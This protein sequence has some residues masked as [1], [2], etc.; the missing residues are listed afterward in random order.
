VT[1]IIPGEILTKRLNE[2][3]AKSLGAEL[4]EIV[5]QLEQ[6]YAPYFKAV[7]EWWK[8]YEAV[9]RT[10]TKNFPFKNASNVVVPFIK[11]QVDAAVSR[12]FSTFTRTDRIWM[13]RTEN[14]NNEKLANNV[15]RRINWGARGNDFDYKLFLYDYI[16]ELYPIG[17]ACAAINYRSELRPVFFGRGTNNRATLKQRLVEFKRG[18][19]LEHVPREQMLWDTRFPIADAPCVVRRH[20]YSWSELKALAQVDPAWSNEAI[21]SIR[22]LPDNDDTYQSRAV[23]RAKDK[24]ELRD[25]DQNRMDEYDVRE[26][27]VD[28][29]VLGRKFQFMDDKDEL[30]APEIP[31]VVHLHM[32]SMTVLRITGEPYHIPGKPFFS[33]SFRKRSH[34]SFGH[35]MSKH[36]EQLQSI[37][38]TLFNQAIDAQTRANAVWAKT[39]NRRHIQEPLDPSHP[40]LVTDMEEFQEFKLNPSVQPNIALI[41]AAQVMGERTTGIADPALGRETRQGGH[42]SPATS[43]LALMEQAQILGASTEILLQHDIAKMGEALAVLYQQFDTNEDGRL[44]QIFGE[45]DAA[46]LEDYLFPTEP[47]PGSYMFEVVATSA[48]FNPDI[49]IKRAVLAAQ[50]NQQYWGFAIQAAMAV[51]SPQVGPQT[52]QMYMQALQSTGRIYSRFLMASDVDDMENFVAELSG[53]TN[54][55][56]QSIAQGSAGAQGIAAGAGA[57]V[58]GGGV[59]GAPNGAGGGA[60]GPVAGGGLLQ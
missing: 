9:P 52:K 49:Q 16:S 58:P 8:W 38:T 15:A 11:Q 35:G 23:D 7:A 2:Q 30:L 12:T 6:E 3:D 55:A 25:R 48:S 28:W 36:L 29:P 26:I 1:V 59:G 45:D 50:A 56:A 32:R 18:P 42:P 46:D 19:I 14:S 4:Y 37:Q 5:D 21:E 24:T 51:E 60:A 54:A 31:V 34:R 53:I 41:T 47:I 33:T 17:Q 43:T 39:R 20:C 40:I 57:G 10:E 13:T 22:N 44:Q 27:H